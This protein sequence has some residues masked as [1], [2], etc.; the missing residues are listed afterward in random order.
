M[1]TKTLIPIGVVVALLLAA[2]I[3]TPLSA[4]HDSLKE[5]G[6]IEI[7]KNGKLIER[8]HNTI[9]NL[10]KNHTA[11]VLA[12]ITTTNIPVNV[13]ALS[14]DTTSPTGSE[15]TCPS[16]ITGNGLASATGTTAMV[17]TGNY[18][19]SHTWTA[20]GTQTG[21]SKVCVKTAGGDLFATALLS[22][23]VNL[24][25]GDNLTVTY[26]IAAT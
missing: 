11:K 24:E 25:S 23:S 13:L 21:I 15:T 20:T 6:V 1:E 9:T 2:T 18:S 10:G 19:I 22:T 5:I 17:G 4:P 14:T 7:Y 12:G 3:Y 16:E 26:Y 8:V